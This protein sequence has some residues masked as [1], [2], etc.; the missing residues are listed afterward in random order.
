MGDADA[1]DAERAGGDC[2]EIDDP[3]GAGERAAVDDGD[4]DGSA[5]VEIVN[6]DPTAERKGLMRRDQAEGVTRMV[7]ISRNS[8]LI[9]ER[10]IRQSQ[11]AYNAQNYR[12]HYCSWVYRSVF[13]VLS[14]VLLFGAFYDQM[15]QK[16]DDCDIN[17]MGLSA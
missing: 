13:N 7:I 11:C 3:L 2:R 4:V 17:T 5:V 9:G 10:A 6:T 8:V 16:K 14:S 1:A 15:R 12:S